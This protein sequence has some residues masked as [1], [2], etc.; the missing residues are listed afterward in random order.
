[1]PIAFYRHGSRQTASVTVE[2]LQLEED[3]QRARGDDRRSTPGF[4]L[5][6][7]DLT[8]AIARQLDLPVETQGALVENVEPFTPASDA[9]VKRGDVILE[10]N[11]QRVQSAAGAARELRRISSGQPA[12]L[13]LLRGGNRLFT[14]M[15]KE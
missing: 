12:F 11:R 15:R 6:L 10:V 5:S 7:D 14:E 3:A 1:V 2:E 13:L 8:P 4:G 9:G